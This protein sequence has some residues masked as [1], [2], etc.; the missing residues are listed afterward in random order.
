MR[1]TFPFFYKIF[2]TEFNIGFQSPA[3]DACTLCIRLKN[4]IKSNCGNDKVV[5]NLR[6]Q[7]RIHKIRANAC[8]DNMKQTKTDESCVSFAFDLQH[9]HPL[10]KTPIQEAFYSRQTGFYT[11]CCVDCKINILYFTRGLRTKQAEDQL[12]LGRLYCII[13]VI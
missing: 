6:T 10:P 11:F 4:E 13:Y 3:A 9:V 2:T 5:Q 12:K 1:V 7:L 8:Y